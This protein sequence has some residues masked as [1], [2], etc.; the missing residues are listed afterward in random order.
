MKESDGEAIERALAGDDE[1]FRALV[2]RHSHSLFRLAFRM[3]G[4][5]QD[6]ED[7]V[8]ESFWKAYRHLG[9]YD[10]RASFH[11]WLYRIAANTALDLLE[12]R[13]K[14]SVLQPMDEEQEGARAM[15]MQEHS[16][17]P[18]RAAWS[19]QVQRRV[20]E[21]MQEL[22]PQE[23]LAFVMRHFEE[24]PV[25]EISEA[26]GLSAGSARHSIFRAVKKLRRALAPLVGAGI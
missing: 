23:R 21:A 24:S 16:P 7:V 12:A 20:Q 19:G 2:E 1:G 14:R 3:T 15:E 4:N 6:A 17:G 10:G 26:L 18:E 25:E 11:T 5:Q 8:Q 9:N 22:T 13:K